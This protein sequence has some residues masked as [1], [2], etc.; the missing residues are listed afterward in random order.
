MEITKEV[1]HTKVRVR[2]LCPDKS[3][4]WKVE[5][6]YP[7]AWPCQRGQWVQITLRKTEA[8]AREAAKKFGGPEIKFEK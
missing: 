7:P 4:L 5:L 6:Y 1:K 3:T 2:P 8:L